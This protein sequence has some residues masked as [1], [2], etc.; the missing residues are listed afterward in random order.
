VY[1]QF[2]SKKEFQKYLL[3]PVDRPSVAAAVPAKT[4]LRL[5]PAVAARLLQR[6]LD[7]F[8]PRARK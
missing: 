1:Q 8:Q 5:S 2:M 6:S 4:E 7:S 3:T